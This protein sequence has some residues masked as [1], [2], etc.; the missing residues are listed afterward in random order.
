MSYWKG[1]NGTYEG[2]VRRKDMKPF[3]LSLR[4]TVKSVARDRYD[5]MRYVV[6]ACAPEFVDAMRKGVPSIERVTAMVKAGEPLTLDP[7]PSFLNPQPSP[8]VVEEPLWGTVDQ[9]AKEYVDWLTA[10][11]KKADQTKRNAG[12]ELKRFREFVYEGQ[13]V[14]DM[15]LD[16]VPSAVIRAYQQS[17]VDAKDP[18]NSI[19]TYMARVPALWNFAATEENRLSREERRTPKALYSPVD[20]EMVIRERS[21][22][23]RMLTKA[24]V[25]SMF[26]ATPPQY[27]FPVGCGVLA[28]LRAGEMIHLR[29]IDVDLVLGT[30]TVTAKQV[31]VDNAGRPVV[32]KP[33]TKRSRRMVPMTDELRAF[34]VA[35]T[36]EWA[37]DAWMMPSPVYQGEPLT[38]LG[39]RKHFIQIVERAG[40]VYGQR[41]ST[42][43]TFHTLRHTFASHAA[44]RGMD[45]YTLA[46]LLG[47]SMKTV[48]DVYADL[49]PDHK[50]EAIRKFASA[51]SL[52]THTQSGTETPNES[53]A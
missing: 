35:H 10:H 40:M 16:R 4:T 50:R 42:G 46:K 34:A 44:M 41:H 38:D 52:K 6:R 12:F 37:S 48:E 28:G 24:E 25:E 26:T 2:T 36:R 33:K 8:I 19:S 20:S 32:W 22:R 23:D 1:A 18:I 9:V 27:R 39:F 43:V 11:P 14:G 15:L 7:K 3:H 45:L 47:D 5:A 29:P 17:M 21:R 53:H 49:S 30:I 31:S 13:R 51:F